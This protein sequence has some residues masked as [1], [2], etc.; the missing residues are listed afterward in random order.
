LSPT[1]QRKRQRYRDCCENGPNISTH[2]RNTPV[3]IPR[4]R[5]DSFRIGSDHNA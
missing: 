5:N 3:V 2:C 1:G 4:P